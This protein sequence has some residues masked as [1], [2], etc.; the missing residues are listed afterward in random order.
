MCPVH[1]EKREV[2]RD[3]EFLRRMRLDFERQDA[4]DNEESE[5]PKAL[6]NR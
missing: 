4:V 5:S 6:E 3:M 1:H 2:E